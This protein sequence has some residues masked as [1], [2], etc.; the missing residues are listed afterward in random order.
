MEVRLSRVIITS[1]LWD[2]I[3][4]RDTGVL[5]CETDEQSVGLR[6][7]VAIMLIEERRC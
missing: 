3:T 6:L 7:L 4:D 1:R 2:L 5:Q